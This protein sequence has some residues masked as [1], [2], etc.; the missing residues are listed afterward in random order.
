MI[1]DQPIVFISYATPD[2]NRVLDVVQT[3]SERGIETWI[4]FQKILGGQNWD[5]EIKKALSKATVVVVFISKNSVDRR[6]YVQ[7]ELKSALDTM[8]EKLI[9]DIFLIPVRLDNEVPIPDQVKH[10]HVIDANESNAGERIVTAIEHQLRKIG[11]K[12]V[13][14]QSEAEIHWNSNVYKD[15]WDGAPGYDIEFNWFSISS[16]KYLRASEICEIV[17]GSLLKTAAQFRSYK[18]DSQDT[19]HNFGQDKYT[20]TNTWDAYCT[21]PS[22][23]GRVMSLCYAVNWYGA[24]AAHPNHGWLTYNFLLEPI[25]PI[26]ELIQL[27]EN[28]E[29]AFSK[30]Q[31]FVRTK[32]AEQKLEQFGSN[33]ELDIEWIE[34]GTAEWSDFRAFVPQRDGIQLLFPPYQ[35]GSYAEG[36]YE[37]LVPYE[38]LVDCMKMGYI[39]AM[40]L[41]YRFREQIHKNK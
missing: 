2:R 15:S 8:Q 25:I 4:D 1:E 13:L 37:Q 9:D 26:S 14:V 29:L 39:S 19:L 11:K 33:S 32:I 6:G 3:I 30:L 10:L 22:I 27:F 7:R 36:P 35:V 34:R 28:S 21:A 17:K 41:Q 40:D 20:R 23:V 31:P 24:G 5:F 38:I 16:E 18:L 12:S